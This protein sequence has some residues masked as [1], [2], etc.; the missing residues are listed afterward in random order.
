MSNP[1]D[2]FEYDENSPS[3][4]RWKIKRKGTRGIGSVAGTKT[5]RGHW[6]VSFRGQ[7]EMAARVVWEMFH[8][9]IPNGVVFHADGDLS[10]TKIENLYLDSIEPKIQISEKIANREWQ[11][12]FEYKDG[13]LIWKVDV[14]S[15]NYYNKLAAKA[16]QALTKQVCKEYYKVMLGGRQESHHKIVWEYFNGPVQEGL[17]IDHIDRNPRNNWIENLRLVEL[18]LNARNKGKSKRNTS[19]TTGVRYRVRDNGRA[20]YIAFWNTL[21]GKLRD[22]SFSVSKYG[23]E[24]AEFLAQ[25]YRQQQID[26]LN[27]QGAG[28]TETHGT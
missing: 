7:P 18:P 9:E 5:K 11:N 28:Y 4:L 6:A 17:Q 13:E 27:L 23:E 14:W 8:G 24:L 1:A 26:L 10:N 2:C 16:G 3:C 19:G 15:G 22:R 21:E 20:C 12:L 25:E